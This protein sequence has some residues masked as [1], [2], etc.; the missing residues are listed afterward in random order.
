M[1]R[2][3]PCVQGIVESE[4]RKRKVLDEEVDTAHNMYTTHAKESSHNFDE[5]S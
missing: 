5:S 1:A 4:I 3:A 2:T